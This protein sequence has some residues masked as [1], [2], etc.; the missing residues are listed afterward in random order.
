MADAP[1]RGS[2]LHW[3]IL[4]GLILGAVV[5]GT[6][7]YFTAVPYPTSGEAILIGG[8]AYGAFSMPRWLHLTLKYGADPVGEIFLR[9]LLLTVVPLVFAS[10]AIGVTRLGDLSKLGRMGARTFA[11]FLVTMTIGVGIGLVLVNTI[12]PGEGLDPATV[13]Q[14]QQRFGGEAETRLQ[15]PGFDI[16]TIV[17]I[18]PRNPFRAAVELQMLSIIFL[19]LL[20]GIALTRFS[21]ERTRAFRDVLETVGDITIFIIGL[22]MRIAPVGVFA[23]IFSTTAR[24]GFGLLGQ[25]GQY[26]LVVLVG[27]LI[28]MCVTYPILLRTLARVNPLVFFSRIRL[29]IVTAFSTSSSNATLPTSI[30]VAEE[31][32]K[33]PPPVAGFVLPLGATMNMNGTALFEGVTAVFLAQVFG[34]QLGLLDQMVVVVLCVLTAVG[35]AGVPGGSIPLLAMVLTSV[36]VPATAVFLILGVDR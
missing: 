10:L 16:D 4:L 5:G 35:A 26:V 22:A 29:V 3:R 13:Q 18:V 7:N 1:E 19:A 30:K 15:R 11:Y 28:Q 14:L 6:V 25:L 24:F 17:D 32:L 31:E 34:V 23:L 2:S 8:G 21:P 20:T 33:I 9:L 12:R 27:L 36:G